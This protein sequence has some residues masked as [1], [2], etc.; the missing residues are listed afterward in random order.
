MPRSELVQSLL[1][2]LDILKLISSRPEGM[3]LAELSAV[4]GLKK[5]TIHNLL[6]T[7]IARDMAARG[8][9]N[10]FTAG[11]ALAELASSRQQQQRTQKIESALL[12]LQKLFPGHTITVSTV[13]GE[14]ICCIKRVSPD[15]PG[16]VQSPL[17]RLFMPYSSVSAIALQAAAKPEQVIELEN[18]YPFEE[19]GIGK[20]GSCENFE[21]HKKD[22][23]E[24]G[25]CEQQLEKHYSL[26]FIMP[27]FLVLGFSTNGKVPAFAAFTAAAEKFRRSVW[28]SAAGQ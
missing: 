8:A 28:G 25:Y 20:W 26:A 5:P 11:N 13:R 9:N 27:D 10:R 7:L 2:G 1:R 19:F 3:S 18:C 24:K 4:T 23:L 17:E 16:V 22:V 21:R 14:S 12:A 15:L 6:R